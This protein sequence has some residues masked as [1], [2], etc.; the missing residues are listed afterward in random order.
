MLFK[1]RIK[2]S[3]ILVLN[4]SNFIQLQSFSERNTQKTRLP[5]AESCVSCVRETKDTASCLKTE[6]M[7]NAARPERRPKPHLQVNLI[8]MS[9]LYNIPC[10]K[11]KNKR[12][13]FA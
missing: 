8:E 3:N 2:Y 5:S 11:A 4:G 12:S 6:M 1:C 10:S 13:H 9:Q 7:Q